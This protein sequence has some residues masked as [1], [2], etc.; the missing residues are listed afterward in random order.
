M[1]IFLHS[2]HFHIMK[3][4]CMDH[5]V[6]NAMKHADKHLPCDRAVLNINVVNNFF[7]LKKNPEEKLQ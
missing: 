2:K 3:G 1:F 5:I 6:H 7:S 4:N